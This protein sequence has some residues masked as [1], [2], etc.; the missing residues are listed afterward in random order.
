V[1]LILGRGFQP[2]SLLLKNIK[3]GPNITTQAFKLLGI[4]RLS[5]ITEGLFWHMVD[6]NHQPMG[7]NSRR[8][9]A[10]RNH[11]VSFSRGMAGINY[12]GKVAFFANNRNC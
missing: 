10:Q 11:L 6:F 2:V 1:P 9:P 5:T 8:R 4:Q 7:T 12:N 3:D